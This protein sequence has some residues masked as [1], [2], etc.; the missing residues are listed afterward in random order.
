M[1]SFKIVQPIQVWGHYFFKPLEALAES[2]T[3]ISAA[4]SPIKLQSSKKNIGTY[5]ESKMSFDK[6]VS[7]TCTAF[8][9]H[10]RA[11]HHIRSSVTTE[12][13][14]MIAATI[15]R[16]Q[17]DYC[18][19]LLGGTSVSNLARLQLVQYTLARV[20][21]KKS[22]FSRITPVVS[23]LHWL[24]VRH[25]I[26]FK[27]ATTTFKLL[28]FQQPSCSMLRTNAIT[29]IIFLVNMCSN[30]KKLQRQSP[31]NFHSYIIYL[32]QTGMSSFM[33]FCFQEES[34]TSAFFECLLQHFLTIW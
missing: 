18:N 25:W 34:Q 19:S 10:I 5:L 32:E 27:I 29:S 24:P 17:L 1:N 28:L 31:N 8:Y 22:H 6:Q 23:D 2:I 4:G 11:L 20:V 7:E 15:V 33:H 16:S 9:F 26:S 3:S 14:K 13:C 12:A 21:S 30:M